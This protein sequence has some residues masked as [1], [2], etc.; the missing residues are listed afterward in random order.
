MCARMCVYAQ[1]Y[2]STCGCVCARQC[3]CVCV[4]ARAQGCTLVCARV[5]V[6]VS[7]CISLCMCGVN[8]SECVCV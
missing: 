3:V 1:L 6:F 4:C 7:V 2:V 5:S 8:M